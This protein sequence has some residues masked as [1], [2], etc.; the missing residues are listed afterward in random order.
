MEPGRIPS[1]REL[2]RQGARAAGIARPLYGATK[3]VL[4]ANKQGNFRFLRG[5]APYSLGAI[6]DAG[7]EVLHVTLAHPPPLRQG[8]ETLDRHLNRQGRPPQAL[9]AIELRSPRPFT[10]EGF[11]DFNR[12][13]IELLN[14]RSLLIDGLNPV[15]RTNVAP[16][17]RPPMEVALYGFSYTAPSAAA[18]PSFVIAGAGELK[19]E[20]LEAR[21]I[22]QRGNISLG[23]VRA[24]ATHVL[25]LM[26]E[27]LGGVGAEWRHVTAVEVYTVHSVSE[28]MRDLLLPRAG[29]A[30]V[31]GI[32][33]HFARPP[34]E[35][36]EFEMDVRGCLRELVL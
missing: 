7:F 28:L 36:I 35:E 10:F 29:A 33:W 6:A 20:R 27:R 24:K 3:P 25:G 23:G 11:N 16:E 9:C 26:D 1:R 13:Y 32:R 34:I 19:G 12:R 14:E 21:D 18:G 31:H 5:I 4:V 30:A 22:V 17:V 8:F 15:A 2:L